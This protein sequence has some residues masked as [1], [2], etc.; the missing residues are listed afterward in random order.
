MPKDIFKQIDFSGGL[1]THT[2]IRDL[3][4]N[5]LYKADDIMV[6]RKGTIRTMGGTIAHSSSDTGVLTVDDLTPTPS[7]LWQ[8]SQTHTAFLQTS[9]SGSGVGLR[10]KVT[11]NVSGIP[12]FEIANPG[13]GYVVDEA[14]RFTDPGSTSNTAD[15]VVATLQGANST[16]PT[17]TI[18]PGYGLHR[19][20]HDKRYAN[21][22]IGN[23]LINSYSSFDN[24]TDWVVANGFSRSSTQILYQHNASANTIV[25]DIDGKWT[26]TPTGGVTYLFTYQL[27][28]VAGTI[29]TLVLAGG[30]GFFAAD[31]VALAGKSTPGTHQV[32]V[33]SH[34]DV[35]DGSCDFKITATS[36]SFTD[37]TCDTN[38]S[39]LSSEDTF[40]SDPHVVQCDST[41]NLAVGMTVSGTG[42]A[43]GS[44]IIKIISAT[45][46]K[47]SADTT[48]TNSNQTLT[49]GPSFIMEALD[50][51]IVDQTN[52]TDDYLILG[53]ASGDA[54][55][56]VH[57]KY[58]DDNSLSSWSSTNVLDMGST[59]GAK[60]VY[61]NMDGAIRCSDASGSNTTQ[62]LGYINK[63]RYYTG[64]R[65]AASSTNYTTDKGS[66]SPYPVDQS[67]KIEG[68]HTG[69]AEVKGPSELL[70]NDHS[71]EFTVLARS[72]G[73]G[74][75][76]HPGT[77]LDGS[78]GSSTAT[79]YGSVPS[80]KHAI[81]VRLYSANGDADD[82][83]LYTTEN[84]EGAG[85]DRVWNCAYS[86]I[87]DNENPT[88]QE[89]SLH[90]IQN[91]SGD[92]H[93]NFDGDTAGS[94]GTS[95]EL[96]NIMN[97]NF[98]S[99]K[100]SIRVYTGV[101]ELKYWND[102]ITGV[103]IYMREAGTS[104]WYLQAEV[105]LYK[106][107]K[108]MSTGTYAT[109]G[110][111]HAIGYSNGA[112]QTNPEVLYTETEPL[113][114]PSELITYEDNT[115]YDI[116]DPN[117]EIKFKTAAILGRRV[118]IGNV[119][120]KDREGNE[121]QMPDAMIKSRPNRYD[122]FTSNMIDE[123]SI[124]DGDEVVHLES[125]GDRI[126]QFKKNKLHI[127]SIDADGKTTM[128]DTIMYKGV[129]HSA[130]VA[131][132][133]LGVTWA[134]NLGV[135]NYNGEDVKDLFVKEGEEGG[136]V[137]DLSTWKDFLVADKSDS[138]SGE[139]ELT[140]MVGFFPKGPHIIVYDDISSGSTT[141]PRCFIYDTI[142]KSWTR[143]SQQSLEETRV[144][145]AYKT[146]FVVDGNSDL[147]YGANTMLITQTSN[148]TATSDTSVFKWT[149]DS[150]HVIVGDLDIRTKDYDLGFPGVRKNIYKLIIAYSGGTSLNA[151]VVYMVNNTG[152]WLQFDS[153]LEGAAGDHIAVL[154]PSAKI[155]NAYSIRFKIESGSVK[156]PSTFKIH[157]ISIVYRL[158]NI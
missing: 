152:S 2:N 38:S 71:S 53:D 35:N 145:D 155:T 79:N 29:D 48:A 121:T 67:Y 131:R 19:F 125:Y 16:V 149:D 27:R 135:F 60:H 14:I 22:S 76:T 101:N 148:T 92:P 88:G 137:I 134:N 147:V 130:S 158:K 87:Y 55:S 140:P 143:G 127:L 68:W 114:T 126:L 73:S 47:V 52:T 103:N 44:T 144:V 89:S 107:I 100:A 69:D 30:A 111:Q 136:R 25:Q 10:V 18:N 84:D 36:T 141:D 54:D 120:I 75:N 66:G 28:Q 3:A 13:N 11:T 93:F 4:E 31:N 112:E 142:S 129:K 17:V 32:L 110:W 45:L 96:G 139:T 105:D 117:L 90:V 91:S 81:H 7:G 123:A 9:T 128:E 64:N 82:I 150:Q 1:N 58:F 124:Q 146:N 61:Y 24:G 116:V 37:A 49:F 8:A 62:W 20:P 119:T 85:W 86:L 74:G 23:M 41:A 108:D 5:E 63:E 104:T 42:I 43:A 6:D 102:R 80:E 118:V 51:R 70:T 65:H 154:K 138:G 109:K 57:S 12:T 72:T 94:L 115:G 153:N 46:F 98:T 151:D 59:A 132:T 21:L 77:D 95:N 26:K 156:V 133:S 99:N 106:G 122:V 56:F 40:G 39:A 34:A 83:A 157:D 33:T 97:G 50:L 15:L 78:G 113:F